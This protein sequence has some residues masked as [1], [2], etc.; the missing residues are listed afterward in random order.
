M[1]L[2]ETILSEITS[3]GQSADS[4][5]PADRRTAVR[6]AWQKSLKMRRLID[7]QLEA[8]LTVQSRDI[9]A[10]GISLMLDHPLR[11]GEQFVVEIPLIGAR[12][13]RIVCTVMRWYPVENGQFIVG[14]VFEKMAG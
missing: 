2:A 12:D 10:G 13:L 7:G 14:A 11:M 5:D 6:S 3:A 9:A 4:T 8:P 1:R